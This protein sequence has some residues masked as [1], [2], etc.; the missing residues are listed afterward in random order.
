MI[1]INTVALTWFNY[2]YGDIEPDTNVSGSPNSS[3]IGHAC[4][5]G[6]VRVAM[7]SNPC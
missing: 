2:T 6:D 3:D 4:Y 1:V 5:T 7:S